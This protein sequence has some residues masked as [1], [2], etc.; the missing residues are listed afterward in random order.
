MSDQGYT[1]RVTRPEDRD[2]V[3]EIYSIAREFM[4]RSGNPRQWGDSSPAVSLIDADIENGTGRVI[5]KDGRIEGCFA[6]FNGPDP[7][8]LKIYDG[9]W[10]ND[11]P[12]IVI[13]RIASAG[14]GGILRAC[15]DYCDAISCNIRIDTHRENRVMQHQLHKYGFTYCGTIYIADG[16]PRMAYQRIK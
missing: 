14:K 7:T 10:L 9:E 8:Y 3:L 5:E 11:E 4:K 12:Y 1:V 13:H 16:S 15:L 2:R 6:L